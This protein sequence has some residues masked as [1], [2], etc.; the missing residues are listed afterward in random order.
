MKRNLYRLLIVLFL[1][2]SCGTPPAQEILPTALPTPVATLSSS[3][4]LV[5]PTDS[6]NANTASDPTVFGTIGTTELQGMQASA[7]ESVANAIF[8][9]TM[10]GFVANG[11]VN[12][13]QVLSLKIIPGE[14]SLLAEIKYNVKSSDASWLADGG[15]QAAD[16]WINGNCSRFD[17]FITDTEFQLKNRR[18]CS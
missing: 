16:G 4:T 11:S 5:A 7:L 17:F 14:E 3:I 10:D 15:A 9:K 18:L 13:Y 12:E 8:K 2:S 6:A 1:L